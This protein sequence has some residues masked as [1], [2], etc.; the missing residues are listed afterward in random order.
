MESVKA[1][2][3]RL[4][5]DIRPENMETI[6]ET[7]SPSGGGEQTATYKI[8]NVHPIL[9]GILDKLAFFR[10][11]AA[12]VWYNKLAGRTVAD[13]IRD[14]NAKKELK[15]TEKR[16][17]D[18]ITIP[19]NGYAQISNNTIPGTRNYVF[20]TIANFGSNGGKCFNITGF[21]RYFYVIGEPGT[22]I[23]NLILRFWYLD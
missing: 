17:A 14:L 22:V 5:P 18:T 1:G 2:E 21:D 4:V 9:N 11:H 6:T 7:Y 20:A 3:N 13:E 15:Y 10:T 19:A 12:A 16:I 23:S 8:I